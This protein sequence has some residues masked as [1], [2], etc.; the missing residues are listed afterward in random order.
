MCNKNI[1]NVNFL[2]LI[3]N[4]VTIDFSSLSFIITAFISSKTIKILDLLPI[5]YFL[6]IY[7]NILHIIWILNKSFKIIK[8]ILY[9]L[10]CWLKSNILLH[11]DLLHTNI[12]YR[13]LTDY[14]LNLITQLLFQIQNLLLLVFCTDELEYTATLNYVRFCFHLHNH[15]N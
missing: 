11:K 4:S 9:F 3:R 5:L 6:S 14:L 2:P 15:Q 10:F 7:I 12:F 8:V 1:E 13:Y